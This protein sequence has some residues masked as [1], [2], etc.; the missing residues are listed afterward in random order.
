MN[1]YAFMKIF[2]EIDI[3]KLLRM[4]EVRFQHI[5]ECMKKDPE[6]KE[7]KIEQPRTNKFLG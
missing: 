4:S 5:M 2:K 7:N 1:C 6:F 3:K